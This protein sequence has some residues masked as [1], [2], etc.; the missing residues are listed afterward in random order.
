MRRVPAG[1]RGRSGRAGAGGH[2][3]GH[4]RVR[5][6]PVFGL[7]GRGEDFYVPWDCIQKFGDDIILIDKPFQKR[8]PP[9]PPRRKKGWF[10]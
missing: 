2:G 4:H 3:E 9:P 6:V 10:G 8:Q 7:F 5:A 1:L